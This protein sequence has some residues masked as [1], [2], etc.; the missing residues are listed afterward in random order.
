MTRVHAIGLH[1]TIP[2]ERFSHC[3]FTG[4]LQ[5]FPLVSP[6]PVTTYT[7]GPKACGRVSIFSAAQLRK[8]YGAKLFTHTTVGNNLDV[9]HQNAF[10]DRVLA[11]MASRVKPGDIIAHVYEPLARFVA[12]FPQ[13]I[14]VETGIGYA[15]APAGCYRIFESESWRA[16]HMG[17]HSLTNGGG[18]G[19]FPHYPELECTAVVPN[20]YDTAQWPRGDGG[21]YLLF[22]GRMTSE[23]GI[24][25][26][27]HCA[28][29]FPE[30]AF[31][32]V[33]GEPRSDR[34]TAPN[35]Q[36]L[37]NVSSR[38]ELAALYGGAACTLAPSR[39]WEPFGGVAVE[40]LLTGTPVVCPDYAAFVETVAHPDDGI[41]CMTWGDYELA[42]RL[43]L[44]PDEGW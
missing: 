40:S 20:Y 15:S 17:R 7:N 21:P 26:V 39:F 27:E 5:R 35:I 37:G 9:A 25:I 4:K 24:E 10:Y 42:L 8:H 23:K 12:A 38:G 22:V 28:R 43:V 16:W 44:D 31:K 18:G 29:A 30:I 1:H 34:L 3:A 14:H 11:K 41:R 32:V 36:W 13:A 33:S 6:Y 19:T 2:D